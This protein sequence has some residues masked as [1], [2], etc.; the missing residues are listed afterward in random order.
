MVSAAQSVN[1]I[2][3]IVKGAQAAQGKAGGKPTGGPASLGIREKAK[4]MAG[5]VGG[6]VQAGAKKI[7]GA[8]LAGA[9]ADKV[10]KPDRKMMSMAKESVKHAGAT[11]KGAGKAAGISAGL[12]SILK[13][14]QL[15]TG[16]IGT[17][18][19]I[20][21]ML[22]DVIIMPF[23]PILIPVIKLLAKSVPLLMMLMKPLQWGIQKI[24]DGIGWFFGQVW[25][26][27]KGIWDWATGLLGGVF[28]TIL[29]VLSPILPPWFSGPLHPIKEMFGV[30]K[31]IIDLIVTII[32]GAW[33]IAKV[34]IEGIWSI[35][36]LIFSV[37]KAIFKLYFDIIKAIINT[38]I[39][40]IKGAWE[41]AKGI[42]NGVWEFI[43]TAFSGIKD[44]FS[45]LWD[46]IK[47]FFSGIWDFAKGI[48]N[49]AVDFIKGIPGKI[50][51][52]LQDIWG[53]IKAVVSM[54]LTAIITVKDFAVGILQK[55]KDFFL[56]VWNTAKEWF[57]TARQWLID[58]IKEWASNF[59]SAIIAIKDFAVGILQKIKDFFLGMWD[60]L[61]NWFTT[62]KQWI[63]DAFKT[64]L[65]NF[66]SGGNT[67]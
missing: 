45:G 51:G 47:G 25:D 42:F 6:A 67:N 57:S 18:F 17:I 9:A 65:A 22:V 26:A 40:I 31:G 11:A 64:W 56:S 52:F 33:G 43:K 23:M 14:S 54:Y 62:A 66:I 60:T 21:G 50:W 32:K 24:V 41:I 30:A 16:I 19:Q 61:K 4:T 15:F 49:G 2:E 53:I 8:G 46:T 44:F 63:I 27:I 39:T 36:K 10:P 28:D 35:I 48:F 12:S 59:I 7:P 55:I 37:Y 5:R 38:I 34:I 13:Q 1:T 3:L 58:K 20:A 29:R